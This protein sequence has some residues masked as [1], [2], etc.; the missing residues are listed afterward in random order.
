MEAIV[1]DDSHVNADFTREASL[2]R[3]EPVI[4]TDG[5]HLDCQ[6]TGKPNTYTLHTI[7][8]MSGVVGRDSA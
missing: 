6:Q 4:F 7:H 8:T 5:M 2:W 1:L 3:S